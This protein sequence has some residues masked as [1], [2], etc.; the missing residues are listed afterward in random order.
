MSSANGLLAHPAHWIC[1]SNDTGPAWIFRLPITLQAGYRGRMSHRHAPSMAIA[2]TSFPEIS[3]TP[4]GLNKASRLPRPDGSGLSVIVAKFSC[5]LSAYTDISGDS[6]FAET[7]VDTSCLGP[8][9]KRGCNSPA[10]LARYYHKQRH[11]GGQGPS[12]VSFG[13][14]CVLALCLDAM[15][16]LASTASGFRRRSGTRPDHRG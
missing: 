3:T 6:S 5:C 15:P 16:C 1:Y 10:H 13:G 11:P 12:G 7:S 14:G 9:P 2:A 8:F 4:P